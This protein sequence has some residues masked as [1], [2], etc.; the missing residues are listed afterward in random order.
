MDFLKNNPRFSFLYNKKPNTELA[1]KITKE[2]TE[3]TLTTV[4]N[5]PNGLVITNTAKKINSFG[6]YEWVNQIQNTGNKPTEVITELF[7]ADF[8]LPLPYE[9]PPKVSAY[10]PDTETATKVYSPY[11]SNWKFDEFS[12]DIDVIE[13]NTRKNHI[14]VGQEKTYTNASGRSSENLAPFFNIHKN[15][16]G[17]IFAIG[18]SGGWRCNIKR[19]ENSVEIRTGISHTGFYLNPGE[20]YRTS[21]IVVMPYTDSVINAQN[22]WRRLLKEKYSLIGT[23]GRDTY[24]PFCAGIWG[25]MRTESVLSRIETI[26]NAKLP[27]EYIWMDAG[28]YG[29]D[30]EPTQNEFE[31]NWNEKAGDWVVSPKIHPNGLKDVSQKVHE[32]G[33]K[34][35]LWFEPER[36]F[37]TSKAAT[38]YPERFIN[39]GGDHLL[40]N[41]A[42]KENLDICRNMLSN[43]INSLKIDCL[44]IDFNINPMDYWLQNDKT[45]GENRLGITEIKYIN[46][47]YA[48]LDLLLEEFP[49]LLIDNCASGGRRIDVEMLRRSVVLWRSDHQCP[50]NYDSYAAQC[51]ALSYNNWIPYSGTGS[52]RLYDIYRIR[53]SYGSSLTTNFTFS[54]SESFGD[55]PEK[56]EFL[57]RT[58]NEYLKVRPFFQEDFYP[59]TQVSNKE[60][61][62]CGYRFNR[63]SKKDGVIILFRRKNS[64][65]GTASFKFTELSANENEEK[66]ENT[67]N[68]DIKNKNITNENIKNEN[69]VYTFTDFDSN[70]EFTFTGEELAQN[71]FTVTIPT[72][73]TSKIYFYSY[74]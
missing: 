36:A 47:L 27:Y 11:G 59:L 37:K 62:W 7:D 28:W 21:S 68:E 40:F 9:E 16:K 34:F 44:R 50:A 6:A 61:V 31:G 22:K 41:F 57:K 1:C 51:H 39:L 56:L 42:K 74:K 64:P 71:G 29:Y 46:N 73:R 48:L 15:G 10:F 70:A 58:Y 12:C 45:E 53:S 49:T 38:E 63:P 17:V 23:K 13:N 65:Y 19:T 2:Q 24:A 67:K 20:K 8:S 72:P 3:N 66:S 14:V 60:D 32:A 30:T 18:W 52:G 26:K 55:D 69:L 4:Y 43:Y 25:G 33:M 5:Y 35:L 54:E